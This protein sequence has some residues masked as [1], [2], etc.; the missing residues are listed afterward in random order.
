MVTVQILNLRVH[1]EEEPPLFIP[2]CV[3]RNN[4]E[5]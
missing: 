2:S 3:K 4:S 5:Q 1:L